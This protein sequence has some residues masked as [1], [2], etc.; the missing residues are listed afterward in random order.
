[1]K[2]Y[3]RSKN[4]ISFKIDKKFKIFKLKINLQIDLEELTLNQKI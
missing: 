3:L 2:L 1:M 4:L